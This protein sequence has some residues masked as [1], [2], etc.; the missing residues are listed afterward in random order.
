VHPRLLRGTRA[1][2]VFVRT[3]PAPPQVDPVNGKLRRVWALREPAA[4][5]PV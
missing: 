2:N 3:D 5:G 4:A 1:Q